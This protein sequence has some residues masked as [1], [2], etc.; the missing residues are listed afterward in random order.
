MNLSDYIGSA[1]AILTFIAVCLA[2]YSIFS[3][4]GIFRKNM[5]AQV[6]LYVLDNIKTELLKDQPQQRYLMTLDY[7]CKCI[8][9]KI[10]NEKMVGKSG[11]DFIKEEIE[12]HRE[13][14]EDDPEGFDNIFAYAK[15]RGIPL[16]VSKETW[17]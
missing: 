5:T 7:Y 13:A 10:L 3:A 14:I 4:Q 17:I 1:S 6:E 8:N 12:T 2:L 16:R 9:F 15:N 11:H